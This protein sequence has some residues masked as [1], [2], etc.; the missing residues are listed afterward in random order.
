MNTL[1]PVI[2]KHAE[3]LQLSSEDCNQLLRLA[4][5]AAACLA[6]AS[7]ALHV[8]QSVGLPQL[9]SWNV[10]H[11]HISENMYIVHIHPFTHIC[12]CV[13]TSLAQVM[14][15]QGHLV[16]VCNMFIS[17]IAYCSLQSHLT[18]LESVLSIYD[19]YL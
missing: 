14:Y 13:S 8:S 11:C 7:E 15:M 16:A 10:H 1:R 18:W 6:A 19:C 3:L 17:G 4:A 5:A 12:V 2:A 9:Y